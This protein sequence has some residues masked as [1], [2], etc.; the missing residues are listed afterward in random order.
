[1]RSFVSFKLRQGEKYFLYPS[2]YHQS[3]PSQSLATGS[4]GH[5]LQTAFYVCRRCLR[6]LLHALGSKQKTREKKR[7]TAAQDEQQASRTAAAW[8]KEASMGQPQVL[9][10]ADPQTTLSG[11]GWLWRLH[12][13]SQPPRRTEESPGRLPPWWRH[14]DPTP[15][16]HVYGKHTKYV[17]S[18]LQSSDSI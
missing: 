7:R 11:L 1:M 13:C 16:G 10:N 6:L 14:A 18:L 9:T 3:S 17:D 8:E 15:R 2:F 5:C 12:C 4:V